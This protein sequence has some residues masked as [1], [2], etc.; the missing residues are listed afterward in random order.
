MR[1]NEESKRPE[2]EK[3]IVNGRIEYVEKNNS[4]PYDNM[5][6]KNDKISGQR[7]HPDYKY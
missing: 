7:A 4:D 2:R 1:N 6:S 5:N 3:A